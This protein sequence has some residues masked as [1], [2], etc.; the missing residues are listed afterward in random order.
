[1][2]IINTAEQLNQSAEEGRKILADLITEAKEKKERN[3]ESKPE[4]EDIKAYELSNYSEALSLFN[5]VHRAEQQTKIDGEN[6][7]DLCN[8]V[9]NMQ[10]DSQDEE[11]GAKDKNLDLLFQLMRDKL[12]NIYLTVLK[13][14]DA[15]KEG[16]V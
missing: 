8:R 12:S 15:K 10:A 2:E 14:E 3:G 6:Y 1:M 7:R 9:D 16:V 13:S 5:E 4:L 11:G